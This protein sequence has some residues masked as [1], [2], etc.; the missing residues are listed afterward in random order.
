MKPR[1]KI[2]VFNGGHIVEIRLKKLH[3][4]LGGHCREGYVEDGGPRQGMVSVDQPRQAQDAGRY[5]GVGHRR[6]EVRFVGPRCH[7]HRRWR[8][9][10]GATT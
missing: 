9:R 5:G 6:D 8:W 3:T 4:T 10:D 7:I 1:L 2:K